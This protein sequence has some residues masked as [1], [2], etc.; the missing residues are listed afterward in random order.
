MFA[1]LAQYSSRGFAEGHRTIRVFTREK[2][3]GLEV[4]AVDV[5]DASSEGKRTDFAD[6]AELGAYLWDKLPQCELVLEEPA[7]VAQAWAFVTCGYQTS[8][9]RTVVYAKEVDGIRALRN[10]PPHGA[11]HAHGL[12]LLRSRR[13]RSRLAFDNRNRNQAERSSPSLRWSD[14][15]LAHGG[16]MKST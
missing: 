1:P 7:D 13:R 5:V 9:S 3:I 4:F 12:R 16:I 6:A 10:R 2:A 8:N 14:E 15:G 11:P